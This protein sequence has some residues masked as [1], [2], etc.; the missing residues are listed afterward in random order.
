M[1]YFFIITLLI[2]V[3]HQANAG[4][5]DQYL[6]EF[7]V[8]K[9]NNGLLIQFTT[10]NGFSC[11]DIRIKAGTDSNQLGEIHLF[12]G[13][14]GSADY[15]VYYAFSW[16]KPVYNQKIYIRIDLGLFG[17]THAVSTT[18]N[19]LTANQSQVFPNPVTEESLLIYER[20]QGTSAKVSFYNGTGV[21]VHEIPDER[22][23]RIKLG[24]L[25]LIPGIY[26]YII[27]YEGLAIQG[28]FFF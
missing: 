1:R 23:G 20:V 8:V 15:E 14:C 6:S 28:R 12:P 16:E 13:I 7:N 22:T 3:L 18:I 27:E 4:N 19:R 26:Y 17:E 11:E 25:D 21:L 9:V 2:S 24:D 10:S 5:G